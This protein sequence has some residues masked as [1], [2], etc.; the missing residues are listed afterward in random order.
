[1]LFRVFPSSFPRFS[2]AGS[3][4][5]GGVV[6]PSVPSFMGFLSAG[7]A[8][9]LLGRLVPMVTVLIFLAPD[10]RLQSLE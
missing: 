5:G 2:V 8:L 3:C 4:L 9:H 1:M 6:H 7:S 10:V